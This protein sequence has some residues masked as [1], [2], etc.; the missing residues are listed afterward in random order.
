MAATIDEILSDLSDYSDFEETGSVTRARS[1][2]T[3]AIRFLQ[4]PSASADQGSSLGYTPAAIQ[5]Q[6][7]IARAFVRANQASSSANSSVRFLTTR[8]GFRR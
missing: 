5:E 8:Q 3:A 7:R 4:Q 2:I 1:F 6:L